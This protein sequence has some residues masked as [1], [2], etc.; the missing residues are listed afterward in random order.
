MVHVF[1]PQ[2]NWPIGFW[3]PV[4]WADGATAQQLPQGGWPRVRR[5]ALQKWLQSAG[6]TCGDSCFYLLKRILVFCFSPK[7]KSITTGHVYIF[8]RGLSKWRLARLFAQ[9]KLDCCEQLHSL[10]RVLNSLQQRVLEEEQLVKQQGKY[11]DSASHP[12]AK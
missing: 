1:D 9:V 6:A 11:T 8:P 10:P 4:S 7:R 12:F 5:V 2:P 3:C